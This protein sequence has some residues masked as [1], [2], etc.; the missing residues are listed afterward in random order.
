MT[1]QQSFQ[2]V[3]FWLTE[4]RTNA[5]DPIV[6]LVGNKTDLVAARLITMDQAVEFATQRG[7]KYYETSAKDATN[8]EKVFF[9]LASE[10]AARHGVDTTAAPPSPRPLDVRPPIENEPKQKCCV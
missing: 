3:D 5:S 1:N 9:E 6:L 10:M 8:I 4:A 7:L 2:N